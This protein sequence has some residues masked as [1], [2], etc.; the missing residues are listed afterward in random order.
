MSRLR[1]ALAAVLLLAPAAGAQQTIAITGGRVATNGPDGVIESGTV[2]IEGERIAAVGAD[3][4]IPDD[5]VVIDAAG[6]WVTPGLFSAYAQIGLVEIGQEPTTDDRAA[7][8]ISTFA[9]A[10]EAAKDFNPSSSSVAVARADG[11]TRAALAPGSDAGLFSGEGTVVDT[12]GTIDSVTRAPAFVGASLEQE[13]IDLVGGTRAAAYTFLEAALDDAL[14]YP[15]LATESEGEV[16]KA[17]DAEALQAAVRGEIPLLVE[18]DRASDLLALANLAVRYDDLRIVVVGGA[19]AHLV[20]DALGAAGVAVILDPSRNLPYTFDQLAAS[21]ATARSLRAA[22]VETAIVSFT[23]IYANPGY[24]TQYAGV[25]VAHGLSWTA[26]LDAITGAP[27]RIF[28][29]ADDLGSLQA[30][31]IADVVIWDGDPLEAMSGAERVFVTGREFEP[32]SRQSVLRERYLEPAGADD[33]PQAY[34]RP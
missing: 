28:G 2:L 12:S 27:A 25:A 8:A 17:R 33:L 18:A 20:A 3:V 11:V 21:S 34:R 31:K 19:E 32:R 30:G 15:N 22:G 24:L 16:L 23:D 26:A 6:K 13:R 29:L 7:S 9:I 10:L 1:A 14:A 5:A 4:E